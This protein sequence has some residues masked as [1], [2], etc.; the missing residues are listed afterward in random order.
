MDVK[1][2][3][4]GVISAILILAVCIGIGFYFYG[5]QDE[6]LS[7]YD[8]T[9]LAVKET[10][11]KSYNSMPVF[12]KIAKET[13]LDVY[14]DD[15]TNGTQYNNNTDPVGISGID[16]IYHS[17]FSNLKLYDYG[18]R[19]RIAAIDE[20]LNYMPNFSRI[21]SDRPDIKEA[22]TS[23]DGHIYSLPRVEEMGLKAYPNILFINKNWLKKLIDWNKL[24]AGL[25][26]TE[27]DLKDGLELTRNQYKNILIEFNNNDMDEKIADS[28]EVPLAFVSGNWQGNES[29]LIASFG[30]PENREHKTIVNDKITF[31]IEDEKWYE[32]IVELNDWYRQGLIRAVS[33]DDKQGQDVFIA[34][35]QDGQY[36]SFYWWEK[37]TVVQDDDAYIIVKPLIDDKTGKRYV[38]LSNEQ[39]IEAGECVILSS[40]SDKAT[41]LSYFD[42]FFEPEYSAQ[43]NYG[44]IESGAFLSQKT[45]GMLIPNDD[46]GVQSA[47]DF[48]MKNAPYGVVY[49]PTTVWD[50]YKLPDGAEGDKW[51]NKVQMESRAKL[52][53]ELLEQYV[54]PFTFEG[55]RSIPNLNYTQEELNTLNTAESSLSKNIRGWMINSIRDNPP[56]KDD[57]RKF[58]STNE[59]YISTI[60]ELNQ[61]AYDRY[62]SATKD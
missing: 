44:S 38:G 52:R 24:P 12:Q 6:D 21:L 2:I 18:R 9:I 30:I 31:T 32:A 13:G 10:T 35:G 25:S 28:K 7:D 22:L 47:D 23:P 45:D 16:A 17:G 39:E 46:H 60:K 37:S 50:N 36:G 33:F 62:L 53:T 27:A 3:V 59:N 34:N 58:L 14:W 15:R 11:V 56:S 48:R 51:T 4:T 55:A 49:L 57:W 29:D 40:C 41:L 20:Y 54:K 61:R 43:L 26:L 19:K 42:K 5:G 8:F 1:K